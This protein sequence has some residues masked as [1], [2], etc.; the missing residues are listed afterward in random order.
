MREF[1]CDLGTSLALR[2]PN[3]SRAIPTQCYILII[4][5]ILEDKDYFVKLF[6]I[7]C[8][9]VLYHICISLL[10]QELFQ[11]GEVH[12]VEVKPIYETCVH[13]GIDDA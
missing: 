1:H 13:N 9:R 10:I 6:C 3:N 2:R 5:L 12:K 8:Q 11:P 7:E 4:N